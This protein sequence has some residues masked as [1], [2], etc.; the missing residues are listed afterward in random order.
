MRNINEKQEK[1]HLEARNQLRAHFLKKDA[2]IKS[3]QEELKRTS[4]L[5]KKFDKSSLDLNNLLLRQRN[6]NDKTEIGFTLKTENEQA[7]CSL[8]QEINQLQDM[9]TRHK[10]NLSE[11]HEPLIEAQRLLALR[12]KDRERLEM[13]I[14]NLRKEEGCSRIDGKNELRT[15][16]GYSLQPS[17]PW[18]AGRRNLTSNHLNNAAAP[19]SS[20]FIR[21]QNS[22]PRYCYNS[23]NFGHKDVDCM[24][25]L[26]RNFVRN[27]RK[28][29]FSSI[30]V[31]QT[32]NPFSSL[33]NEEECPK[34]NSF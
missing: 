12:E 19:R 29:K 5:N 21:H 13:E 15:S 9:L 7:E 33:N 23:Y 17:N 32:K 34:C 11:I 14:S 22:F 2:E 30:F 31:N 10:S 24:A 20:P 28:G 27:E 1:D 16:L 26:R 25:P 3:L 4:P 8:N 18:N 6:V